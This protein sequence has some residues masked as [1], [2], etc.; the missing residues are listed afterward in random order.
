MKNIKYFEFENT[1]TTNYVDK[2]HHF[3]VDLNQGRIFFK[4]L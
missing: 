4:L 1:K 2:I 3:H